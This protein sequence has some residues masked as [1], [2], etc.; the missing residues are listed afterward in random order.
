MF[1]D[2]LDTSHLPLLTKLH[3]PTLL[4][5]TQPPTCTYLPPLHPPLPTIQAFFICPLMVLL[6]H[7]ELLE[8][9]EL[10]PL[11][12]PFLCLNLLMFGSNLH[13][14]TSGS[15]A[16]GYKLPMLIP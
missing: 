3:A 13:S 4:P 5:S 11:L 14:D 16:P 9:K 15:P 6:R 12:L 2:K 1:S 7:V 10:H 8:Q